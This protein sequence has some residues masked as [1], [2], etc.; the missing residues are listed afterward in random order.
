MRMKVKELKNMSREE[1]IDRMFEELKA[2]AANP[3]LSDEERQRL[4]EEVE[5]VTVQV[6]EFK[7]RLLSQ[8]G[9]KKKRIKGAKRDLVRASTR[10]TAAKR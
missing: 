2:K 9:D 3:N 5:K 4:Q 6:K 10:T 1:F 8:D 7:A